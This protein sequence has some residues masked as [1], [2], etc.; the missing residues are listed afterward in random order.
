AR[1]DT[2]PALHAR[3]PA[4]HTFLSRKWYFDELIDALV[5]RPAQWLGR[6]AGSVLDRGVI[7]GGVTG[8]TSGAVRALSAGVRR[9]QTG[10]LRFYAAVMVIGL[11]GMALYF[12][13]SST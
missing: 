13:I 7:G 6:F 5:V 3:L 4:V 10:F 11:S 8:G 1:P 12:L 2:A 9:A